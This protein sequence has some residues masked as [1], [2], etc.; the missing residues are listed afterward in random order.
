MIEGENLKPTILRVYEGALMDDDT[1]KESILHPCQAMAHQCRFN[2]T[3]MGCLD[4]NE[5]PGKPHVMIEGMEMPFLFDGRKVHQK[6]RKP[7]AEELVT[8]PEVEITAPMPY[9]PSEETCLQP[10]RRAVKRKIQHSF[11]RMEKEIG[12]GSRRHNQSCVG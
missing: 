11:K 8:L 6:I 10:Q 1:Q 7:T 9:N 4:A 2:L 12:V 3:S 5:Q